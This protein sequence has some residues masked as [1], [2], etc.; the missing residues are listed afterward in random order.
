MLLRARVDLVSLSYCPVERTLRRAKDYR[1]NPTD[2]PVIYKDPASIIPR[3][4]QCVSPL[5]QGLS[6][7]R[8]TTKQTNEKDVKFHTHHHRSARELWRTETSFDLPARSTSI[9]ET[10]FPQYR[11]QC[12][13]TRQ[14]PP[15]WAR[16]KKPLDQLGVSATPSTQPT[17]TKIPQLLPYVLLCHFFLL[18]GLVGHSTHTLALSLIGKWLHFEFWSCISF[19]FCL[20][21]MKVVVWS[22]CFK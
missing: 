12:R 1:G 17:E 6:R 16:R 11:R 7:D 4:I 9:L 15:S 21:K 3:P 20:R 19:Y 2:D 10:F 22:Y 18:F 13:T 14:R 5:L 8:C